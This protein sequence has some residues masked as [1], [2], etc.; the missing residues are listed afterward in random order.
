MDSLAL[1]SPSSRATETAARG[2][3]GKLKKK[4]GRGQ[5]EGDREQRR[6]GKADLKIR[7]LVCR[8]CFALAG[9]PLAPGPA[10]ALWR[11]VIIVGE[12]GGRWCAGTLRASDA[13]LRRTRTR[14][15]TA[16]LG[17]PDWLVRPMAERTRGAHGRVSGVWSRGRNVRAVRA[18]RTVAGQRRL[19]GFRRLERRRRRRRRCVRAVLYLYCKTTCWTTHG[20]IILA[21]TPVLRPLH[22]DIFPRRLGYSGL[23]CLEVD[24]FVQLVGGN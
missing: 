4:G 16:G 20:Q 23:E 5:H 9:A 17:Y 2:T 15:R 24:E 13:S 1:P 22:K 21:N 3:A 14:T 10:C 12:D 19:R 6:R 18:R 7:P 8:F 11:R